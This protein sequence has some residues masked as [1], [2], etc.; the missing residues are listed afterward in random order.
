MTLGAITVAKSV[1][2]HVHQKLVI[3]RS[4][5][6]HDSADRPASFSDVVVQPRLTCSASV[7]ST[8]AVVTCAPRRSIS[9]IVSTVACGSSVSSAPAVPRR[10]RASAQQCDVACP[11]FG[12]VG[13]HDAA[14]RSGSAG[15]DV[16]RVRRE[17]GG[18]GFCQ[19]AARAKTRDKRRAA[20]DRDLI[21]GPV[22][23]DVRADSRGSLGVVVG[24]VDVDQSAPVVDEFL[25]ADH[26]AEAP[27]GCLFNGNRFGSGCRLRVGGDQVEAGL[28]CLRG[29]RRL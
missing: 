28:E 26:P 4:R 19:A 20:A 25:V 11:P 12:E 10:H 16:C 21:L 22:G 5:G 3:D 6:V 23:E 8:L 27:D 15:D 29:L 7:I 17:F 13:G 2:A 1:L 24:V 9:R 14:Q 18:K